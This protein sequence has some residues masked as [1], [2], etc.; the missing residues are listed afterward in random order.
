[1]KNYTTLLTELQ[2]DYAKYAPQ[3]AALNARA[4][5]T[6]VDGGSHTLRLMEPFPPRIV[7]AAGGWLTDE[8]GH[9]LLDFWQGHLA[10]I[11]GH[12]PNVIT[13]A[14]AQAFEE[15]Y[16]LQTGFTDRIQ[17]EAAELLCARTGAERARFT[18]SGTLAT[19]Y[20]I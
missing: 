9:T 14:L 19:M 3:S 7:K 15:G 8:D 20:A 10:N 12:N 17:V 18:T 5:H 11:L 16:G 13:S 2:A 1:M 4:K 6:L